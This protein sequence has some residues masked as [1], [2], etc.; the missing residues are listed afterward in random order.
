[1]F[2]FDTTGQEGLVGCVGC[3]EFLL[4]WQLWDVGVVD[5]REGQLMQARLGLEGIFE[6]LLTVA[7]WLVKTNVRVM[8]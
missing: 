7:L 2:T 8:S 5:V 3:G 1:M 6:T 4:W